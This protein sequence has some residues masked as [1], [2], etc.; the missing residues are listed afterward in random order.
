MNKLLFTI[1]FLFSC[2]FSGQLAYGQNEMPTEYQVK[3]VFLYNFINFV[4]WP[5]DT[6]TDKDD[7]FEICIL[8]ED[9]F[10]GELSKIVEGEKSKGNRPIVISNI[11][12]VD[13]ALGCQILF[14]SI[15]NKRQL[16]NITSKLDSKN[17]L[18]VGESIDFAE[19]GGTIGFITM[20]NR[21]QFEI[22]ITMAEKSNLRIDSRLQR[23]AKKIIR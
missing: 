6:F 3:A 13:E 11:N 21:V 17:V 14:T 15:A 23:I 16:K 10:N 9:P 18:L 8:G 19:N 1:L 2:L 12:S 5:D 20:E 22:N 4:T 7:P